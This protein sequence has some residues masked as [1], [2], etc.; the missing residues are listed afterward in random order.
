MGWENLGHEFVIRTRPKI[1]SPQKPLRTG[2]NA[3]PATHPQVH[4][5]EMKVE[6]M[7]G[8]STE[9]KTKQLAHQPYTVAVLVLCI[10]SDS[11][12]LREGSKTHF[13][14]VQSKNRGCKTKFSFQLNQISI[15]ECM[16]SHKNGKK[17]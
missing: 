9:T 12:H 13:L 7:R 3:R 14:N 11:H 1:S 17:T 4:S 6:R 16:F 5:K 15:V 10:I 8:I 2:F